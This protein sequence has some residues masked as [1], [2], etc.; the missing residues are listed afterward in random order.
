MTPN[1]IKTILITFLLDSSIPHANGFGS[2]RRL[3]LNPEFIVYSGLGRAA[4]IPIH[5]FDRN[6]KAI[7]SF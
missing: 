6:D 1:P 2:G 5:I 7:G 3:D 4:R